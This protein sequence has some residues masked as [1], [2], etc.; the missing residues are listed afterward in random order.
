MTALALRQAETPLTSHQLWHAWTRDP[1]LVLP[2][3]LSAALFA[4]GTRAVW[5]SAGAGHGVRRHEVYA[6]AAGWLTLAVALLSPLH[7][8]G[9]TLFSAHMA[10]HELLM[11]IAAPL[12][13]LGRPLVPFVW[14]LP[15]AWRRVAGS[16][17]SSPKFRRLWETLTR[18][19][20]VWS[21]HAAAI[22]LWHLP[23]LFQASLD[24]GPVHALQHASFLGT[25]LLFW[26]TILRRQGGRVGTP[27]AV[28]ALFTTAVHTSL[29]GALLTFSSRVWYPLYDAMTGAWGLTPLEDQQLAGLIMWV[30]AGIAYAAAAIGL[31]ATWLVEPGPP[32]RLFAG[33]GVPVLLLALLGVGVGGCQGDGALSAQEAARLTGGGDAR[34]G[35][36]AIRRFGCGACHAIPGIPGA[37]GQVGP[38]LAGVGG[39]SYIAGVLTNTPDHMVLWIVNPRGVD[40]LT[41]MPA[42]GV[43]AAEARNMAAYL[44]SAR[45]N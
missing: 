14:G 5:R 35:A 7:R 1:A 24:S 22:W 42:V 26:W 13:V 34:R 23:S 41:A 38:S 29:L 19:A 17:T 45:R 31:L 6:F 8:L 40:P 12:L 18:P 16:W 9:E 36:E 3:V 39:R 2:L 10:Q 11:V 21:L 43:G 30:P 4:L 27:V 33:A 37:E 44:Y 25:A 15:P 32:R 20:T 28:I